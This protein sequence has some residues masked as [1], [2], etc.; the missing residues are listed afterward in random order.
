M[1]GLDIFYHSS[2]TFYNFQFSHWKPLGNGVE[3]TSDVSLPRETRKGKLGIYPLV[4]V[5]HWLRTVLGASSPQFFQPF[6]MTMNASNLSSYTQVIFTI[7]KN[8]LLGTYLHMELRL[9]LHKN[10]VDQGPALDA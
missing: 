1:N 5:N 7:T 8:K 4:P 10:C 9:M 2:F 3:Y 6:L